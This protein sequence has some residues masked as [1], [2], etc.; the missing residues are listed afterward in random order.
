MIALLPPAVAPWFVVALPIVVLVGL[1]LLPFLDRSPVRGIR[2]RPLWLAAVI[3]I[4][5]ALLVL[6]DYRRRSK[7]TGWP[8]SK[9]PP[10]PVGMVLPP[11]AEKGRLLFAQYGCNSCHPVAGHGR[12]VAVDFAM[13]GGDLSRDKIREY[14]LRPPAG[15]A[16]PSYE[17]RMDED[18]LI[19]ITEFCH[20][21][22][23]FP[24]RD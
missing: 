1:L 16:M 21:V 8:D 13:L 14:V 2:K 11:T 7:F 20:V 19:A 6:S 5:I 10:V 24:L 4:V 23:T 12:K 15:I 17:G 22:Q 18:D 9:P 3:L